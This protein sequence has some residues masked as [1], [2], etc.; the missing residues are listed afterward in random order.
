MPTGKI[1]LITGCM[2]SAKSESLI[3][4]AKKYTLS[5]KK[6]VLIK[7]ALDTRYDESPYTPHICSHNRNSIQATFSGQTLQP[8][9]EKPEI[10]DAQVVLIDEIQ[11][12]S[13]APRYCDKWANEGKIV[14]VAGLNGTYQREEF[15]VISKLIPMT[16]EFIILSAVC[17]L[18]G[19]NAYFSKRIVENDKTELIG[20]AESYQPRCRECFSKNT[21]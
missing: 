14:V 18:C 6:I 7:Y 12:F 21:H 2:F 15:P 4:C 1:I 5:R 11:F 9:D 10:K 13:D 8:F 19:E 3:T 20:G 17:S 16:E